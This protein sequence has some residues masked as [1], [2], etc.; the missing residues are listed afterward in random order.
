VCGASASFAAVSRAEYTL[1]ATI[2][3]IR[4][5]DEEEGRFG[6]PLE[7]LVKEYV[8]WAYTWFPSYT[9]NFT[10]ETQVYA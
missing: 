6:I 5:S 3:F 4:L 10:L 7:S 1:P 9:Q 8:K 2:V